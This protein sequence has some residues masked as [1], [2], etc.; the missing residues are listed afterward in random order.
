M[1]AEEKLMVPLKTN[2][3]NAILEFLVINET[4]ISDD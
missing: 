2:S 4:V 3:S 1:A